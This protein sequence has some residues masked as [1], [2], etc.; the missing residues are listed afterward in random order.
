[1]ARDKWIETLQ[2]EILTYRTAFEVWEGMGK[3]LKHSGRGSTHYITMTEHKKRFSSE[4]TW[5]VDL[6]KR[7]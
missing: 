6:W 3:V 4:S 7:G 5:R 1:M 2:D